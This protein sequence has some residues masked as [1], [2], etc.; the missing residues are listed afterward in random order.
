M[1]AT[2]KTALLR[3]TKFVTVVFAK[4]NVYQFYVGEVSIFAFVAL[5]ATNV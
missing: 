5:M 3:V 2:V 4:L 1:R